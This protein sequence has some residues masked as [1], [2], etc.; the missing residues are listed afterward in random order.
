MLLP[1]MFAFLGWEVNA[2]RFMI[3]GKKRGKSFHIPFGLCPN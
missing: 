1:M 2:Q 3:L